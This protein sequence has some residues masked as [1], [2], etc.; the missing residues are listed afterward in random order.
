MKSLLRI[1]LC[2]V[3][4][5]AP[6]RAVIFFSTSDPL[7][8]TTAPTG[9][10]AGSGW[11]LQGSWQTDFL[12]TPI[13]PQYFITAKHLAGSI[14]QPFVFQSNPY[15]TDAFFDDPSSDL[16]IWHVTAPFPSFAPL[17][18][19][20]GEVGKTAAVFGRGTQRGADLLFNS[21]LAGWQWGAAD[22]VKRWGTNNISG[23]DSTVPG[24]N[25]LL[26]AKFDPASGNPNEMH[27]SVGDS[28]GGV[29]IQDT[30]N[31]WKLAGINYSVDQN[32]TDA[33]GNGAF[34]AA[35]FEQNGFFTDGPAP[36]TYVPAT[37]PGHF[38]ATRISAR[39]SFIDGVITPE[40]ATSA[41]LLSALAF[42]GA[43]RRRPVPNRAERDSPPQV[44]RRGGAAAPGKRT[45]PPAAAHG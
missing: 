22:H 44:A 2:A 30:D 7:F 38:Y 5:L 20:S 37:G 21:T 10:Y 32:Y 8:N 39:Q 9:A 24:A 28:G 29:F 13:A 36:G 6:A 4:L 11:D 23:L 12:G 26:V 42:L 1:L 14:G 33:A 40:P 41:F 15:T 45:E 43:R 35:L 17:F 18:P 27:I 3:V 19:G 25:D 16:R 31:V 34:T